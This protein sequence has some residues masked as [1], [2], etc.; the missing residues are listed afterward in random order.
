MFLPC[1][2]GVIFLRQPTMYSDAAVDF[3]QI[4]AVGTSASYLIHR[5]HIFFN[6]SVR[7]SPRIPDTWQPRWWNV[8]VRRYTHARMFLFVG[9]VLF[10]LFG[11]SGIRWTTR[12]YLF[13]M[14]GFDAYG[15]HTCTR[16]FFGDCCVFGEFIMDTVENLALFVFRPRFFAVPAV[17]NKKR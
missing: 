2:I 10:F 6:N 14:P 4:A 7:I 15:V 13:F 3:T 17:R 11:S 16:Y 1:I 5:Y 8:P 9:R 12:G